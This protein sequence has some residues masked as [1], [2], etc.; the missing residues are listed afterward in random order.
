MNFAAKHSAEDE[1]VGGGITEVLHD[2]SI[3]FS[4]LRLSARFG[5][6]DAISAEL[7]LPLRV[8]DM[9]IVY[10]DPETGTPVTLASPDIHHREETLVGVFDPWLLAGYTWSKD[11]LSLTAKAGLTVPLGKTEE[12]PF[13]LGDMGLTH[14]HLQF[15]SGIVAPIVGVDARYRFDGWSLYGQALTVQSLYESGKSF[16]PGDRYI[17]TTSAQSAFGT[18][19]WQFRA[20][21]T[22]QHETAERWSGS[23]RTDE[24]NQGRTDLLAT[25][26]VR[27]I[28]NDQFS[29]NAGVQIPLYTKVV[30]GQLEYPAV[31]N[32]GLTATF[33][34]LGGAS[35][36]E[37]GDD[38]GHDHGDDDGHDHGDDDGHDGH[39][40]GDEDHGDKPPAVDWTGIDMV[41]IAKAGEAVPLVPVPGKVTVTDFWAPW[42]KPCK[43][44][45]V[46][47]AA[48]ARKYP[49]QI[50]IRK[51]NV[52]DWDSD[53]AK[54]YLLPGKFNLPHVKV[55]SATGDQ[56]L[57]VS[58]SPEA[59]AAAIEQVLKPPTE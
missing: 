57:E 58:D 40:D 37:H 59:L 36:D 4:E 15:G 28:L 50:A 54:A 5:I 14:Q 39:D 33:D 10:R 48:L 46:L 18:D 43:K 49:G 23:L 16:E 7:L 12:D 47:L 31:A 2:Q 35:K 55:T 21:G 13:A 3:L 6:T 41:E 29:V 22:F 17:A 11:N 45:D 56:L 42:C 38:D 30:G 19:K 24:G 25:L 51:V 27:R 32:I 26:D 20:G 9:G 44:L 1:V 34:L 8:I 53:A 52:V